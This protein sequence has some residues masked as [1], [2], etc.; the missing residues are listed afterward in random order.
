MTLKWGKGKKR[1]KGIFNKI[2]QI[3]MNIQEIKKI[4]SIENK[5]DKILTGGHTQIINFG[6]FILASNTVS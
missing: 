4:L 1:L 5:L 3:H 6:I 2:L